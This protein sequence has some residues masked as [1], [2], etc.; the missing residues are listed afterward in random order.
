MNALQKAHTQTRALANTA[1]A[2]AQLLKQAGV[3]T[4]SPA[5]GVSQLNQF[6]QQ[7]SNRRN[8]AKFRG[9]VYAAVNALAMEGAGQPV[10]VG[11]MKGAEAPQAPVTTKGYWPLKTAGQ[12]LVI[13]EGHPLLNSLEC[14]NSMQGQWQFTYSFIANLCLTGWSFVVRDEDE[15][16]NP[17]FYSVPTTWVRPIHTKGPFAEFKIVN[18]RDPLAEVESSN[19][20]LLTRDQ[21]AFA[22]LPDPSD[23]LGALPPSGAQAAGIAI[24]EKIQESQVA[25]FDNG[26]FPSVVITMGQ[27][28]HPSGD[29][30]YRPR[31]TAEQRRQVYAA[32]RK[33]SGG[34]ANYGNPAIVDG[35]IEKIDR[36]SATQ[37]EM[38]WEK[39]EKTVRTRILSAFCVH[40][41]ILGEEMAGSYA[42]A[43]IVESRFYRRVNTYLAMQSGVM[44]QLGR[45]AY[46]AKKATGAKKA[47]KLIVEYKPCKS[48][49]PSMEKTTWEQA[50]TRGDV[51]QNEF[52]AWMGL[53]PDED[54]QE[55]HIEKSLAAPITAIAEK[56]ESGA[57]SREQALEMLK[58]LGLPEEVAKGI[59]GEG[60]PKPPPMAPGMPGAPGAGVGAKPAAKPG[61]GKPA[62]PKPKPAAA[63]AKKALTLAAEALRLEVPLDEEVREILELAEKAGS[64]G[65]KQARKG[66]PGSGNFNHAGCPGEVGG[67]CKPG[68]GGA[69][70]FESPKQAMG[71]VR[72]AILNRMGIEG[73][74]RL[75]TLAMCEIYPEAEVWTGIAGVEDHYWVKIGNTHYDGTG[76]PY[77]N[78][79]L[80][81]GAKP[82]NVKKPSRTLD[83]QSDV[84]KVELDFAKSIAEDV[85]ATSRKGGPG[86]G[87][88]G[89]SG[90]AGK[91]GGSGGGGYGFGELE[92]PDRGYGSV[93]SRTKEIFGREMDEIVVARMCGVPSGSKVKITATEEGVH[94]QAVNDAMG[95]VSMKRLIEGTPGDIRITNDEFILRDDAPKGLGTQIFGSQIAQAAK[96][97][98]SRLECSGGGEKGHWMN[99]YYTWP[100]LGYDGQVYQHNIR[101]NA[102]AKVKDA[103]VKQPPPVKVS[104]LMKS[105]TG[106]D[107]WKENGAGISLK[108]DLTPGSTSRKVFARYV[109]E[110]AKAKKAE[111]NA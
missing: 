22:Q 94:V 44:T 85:V 96:N 28:P 106:R 35:L 45:K 59:A 63:A 97:G 2:R 16:G 36:L 24:D 23:P 17:Q 37:N 91:V 5:E 77:G 40:P 88:F 76:D 80:Y 47:E 7:A 72:N 105:E 38:G 111:A 100:R 27:Q 66:G 109:K 18:P 55:Q 19:V 49:D 51:T 53:P 12:E 29:G 64:G 54:K 43:Y 107:W 10:R 20:P 92:T 30:M 79:P 93:A 74:C 48:V 71:A 108:F 82:P 60:P 83:F 31:L 90:R 78:P 41:F 34:I 52:R 50:R 26:I 95:I 102:G 25:F 62:K 104:R 46:A 42:Q 39:S 57:I 84:S 65:F 21:V 33:V 15:D 68:G 8:Y 4:L 70:M 101:A 61:N 87:N 73:T 99:G 6:Q 9:W 89:H 14:P 110:K 103:P 98:V 67:S 69:A 1:A 32:I 11:K 75:F 81:A 3:L 56:A 58:A 86:S 13:D